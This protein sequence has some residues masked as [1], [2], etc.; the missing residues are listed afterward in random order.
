[1]SGVYLDYNAS[2]LVRPEVQAAMA[3]AL[4]DN[5]N[6]S[7]VHAAGRR[8]RA[9][10]ETARARVADLVGADAQSVIFSSGGT[11]SNAQAIASA[12]AAGFE[13]LIVCASEHPCVAE[14]AMASGKPVKVLPVDARGVIDLGRL[15]E[16]LRAPGKA[17]VAIH[18][19]NNESGVIQPIREA[20]TLV[21]EAGGWLHVDAIQSA[22]KI[23]VSM[24]ALKADSLTLSAHKLGGPQGVGALVLGEGRAAVQIVRGAGQERG[25]RAGTE[26]VPGIHG[27]G[28]AADC[29]ARDLPLA[30]AHKAWRDAAEATV[31]AAGA[32]I[33]GKG[34]PRLPNT[35]FLSVV[36]WD[37][38]QALIVL[39]L[40]G[41]MVSA[42]SA[43]S[44]GKTK[45]SRT[46]V[47]MGRMDLATGGV[48][49]S[50]G[51]GTTEDDWSRFAA[52]WTKAYETHRARQSA[53]VKET[54]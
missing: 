34:A 28:V 32:T 21:R 6:P 1:M 26:N 2:A 13:R 27:F 23:P 30:E 42:G 52:A 18:H 50:G 24:G 36:D 37:S 12:L 39:D 19:A 47:A 20:A 11:E 49:V 10:V 15:S 3:E 40:G 16:L 43:C 45:P 29:A 14:A 8:A 41:I 54:A 53:R 46:I 35:L 9:R 25:L 5:G 48:R 51:W 4:A 22:G 38:P 31:E 7:A 44:S 33:L 17:V